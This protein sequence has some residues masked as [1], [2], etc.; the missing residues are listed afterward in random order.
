[1]SSFFYVFVGGGVGSMC[2]YG[3]SRF[4]DTSHLHYGTL[5]ANVISCLILGFLLGMAAQDLLKS[6]QRLLLMTGFCGGFSTYSTFSGELVQ[7]FQ[8]G[9]MA[10]ASMYLIGSLIAGVVCILI[11]LYL[12]KL[13]FA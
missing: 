3:I 10:E 8:S 9:N 13:C 2:R 6:T 7:L 1:M 4:W 12:A 5:L 11:G